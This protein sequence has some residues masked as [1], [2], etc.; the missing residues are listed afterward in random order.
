MSESPHR[1]HPRPRDYWKIAVVLAVITAAEVA[2]TYLD[3]LGAVVA[4]LLIAMAVAKFWLVVAFFMHL[5]FEAP[6]YRNLFLIG[7]IAT[8]ILFGVVLFTFGVLI[9]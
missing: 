4:P 9:G 7:V 1:P 8:P 6:I 5:R 2:V 3:G